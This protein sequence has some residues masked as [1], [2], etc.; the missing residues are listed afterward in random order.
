[1]NPNQPTR[2][3]FGVGSMTLSTP[4]WRL[5][6]VGECS[7]AA[8][9]AGRGWTDSLPDGFSRGDKE[10]CHAGSLR[11]GGKQ[12]ESQAHGRLT[13]GFATQ[14]RRNFFGRGSVS[15]VEGCGVR[16]AQRRVGIGGG[17]AGQT[18]GSTS[19]IQAEYKRNTSETQATNTLPTGW[20]CR[21]WTGLR[22]SL[23][24]WGTAG[25]R[26]RTQESRPG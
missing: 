11:L 3:H 22:A 7:N 9:K 20:Q 23:M 18:Q 24:G 8:A 16:S 5:I 4:T 25:R 14:A 6:Q 17:G 13:G 2:A 26:E 10:S 1:M 21:D 15:I 19:G 12:F